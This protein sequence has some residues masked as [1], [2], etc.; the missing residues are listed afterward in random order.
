MPLIPAFPTPQSPAQLPLPPAE[1]AAKVFVAFISS[2]DPETNQ[3]WCPDVRAAMPFIEAVFAGE[4]ALGLVVVEVG[5]KPE[6]K[7][8]QNTYRTEWNITSIPS[9]V[10]YERVDGEPAETG[11]LVEGGILSV[12]KLRDFVR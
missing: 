2:Q 11:R 9:L 5:Q 4:D 6:W 1:Y 7:D 3:P 12:E 10:R 8:P